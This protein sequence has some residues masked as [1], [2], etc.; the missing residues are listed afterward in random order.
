MDPVRLQHLMSSH[1]IRIMQA[2]PATW[3]ALLGA[4]WR[5]NRELVVLCGGE[6]MPTHFRARFQGRCKSLWNLYGPTETTI[7][8]SCLQVPLE[9]GIAGTVPIGR[10]IANTRIY[11]LDEGRQPV[12]VGTIGELYIGG[13]G[14]A[15]GYFNRPELTSERFMVDPFPLRLVGGCT[16]LGTWRGICRT[17]TSST[18]AGMTIK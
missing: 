15:R 10:P 8:S 11:L 4:S 14:V 1:A 17:G 6:A 9:A 16:A 13:A 3:N 2:T 12:P 5:G 7:W 18:W